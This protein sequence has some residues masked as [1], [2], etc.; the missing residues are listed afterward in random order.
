MPIAQR[1]RHTWFSGPREA[2]AFG[3]NQRSWRVQ[4][5]EVEKATRLYLFEKEKFFEAL[6]LSPRARGLFRRKQFGF[7][8]RFPRS[9]RTNQIA[10]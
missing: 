3:L 8:R 6:D 7:C 9:R 4:N 2:S 10:S 1:G 5:R